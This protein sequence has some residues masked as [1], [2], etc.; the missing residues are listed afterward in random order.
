M[1]EF[2]MGIF[3]S[4]SIVAIPLVAGI[5]CSFIIEA[6]KITSPKW[7]RA[8]Y[9][10]PLVCLVVSVFLIFAFPSVVRGWIDSILIVVMNLVFAIV[11]Y[12][13]AGTIIVQK[14][15]SKAVNIVSKK[16]R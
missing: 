14:I 6:I 16:N 2:I 5:V 15:I 4:W 7:L 1:E 9:I 8:R 13:I 12:K 10:V 3:G 11:F